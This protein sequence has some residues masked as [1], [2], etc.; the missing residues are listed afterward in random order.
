[1]I[2][3]FVKPVLDAPFGAVPQ[4][5]LPPCGR[6]VVTEPLPPPEPPPLVDAPL[7]DPVLPVPLLVPEA[8]VPPLA[9]LLTVPE[10]PTPLLAMPEPPTPL[11]VA[12]E[13][14][15]LLTV[16]EPPTPLVAPESPAPLLTV[17]EPLLPLLV[18]A[19][20]PLPPP[21]PDPPPEELPLFWLATVELPHADATSRAA[22]GMARS[23]DSRIMG[24]PFLEE[25]VEETRRESE[26]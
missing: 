4:P 2:L 15:P 18:V 22:H 19:P 5:P 24:L 21:A 7:L 1:V 23:Q 9:P 25:Y 13:P 3:W 16:P 10:P 14:A 6:L 26:A 20:E 11:L 8:P 17:P 12:P